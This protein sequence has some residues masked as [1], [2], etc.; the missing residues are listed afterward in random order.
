M[1]DL[2]DGFYLRV[3]GMSAVVDELGDRLFPK[4]APQEVSVPYAVFQVISDP[5]AHHLKGP[6]GFHAARLQVDVFDDDYLRGRRIAKGINDGMLGGA[7]V[8]G[9]VFGKSRADGPRDLGDDT[10]KGFIHQASS[11]LL[12]WHR[13][14]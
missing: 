2:A 8:G 13:A 5:Q 14:A 6:Q 12:V 4:V 10:A 1:A 11:D 3:M 7:T 9:V